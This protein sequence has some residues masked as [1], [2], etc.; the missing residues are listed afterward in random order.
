[1]AASKLLIDS[2]LRTSGSVEDY[3]IDIFTPIRDIRAIQLEA[4][5]IPRSSYEVITGFNDTVNIN[6]G[7]TSVAGVLTGG[8]NYLT[9]SDLATELASAL[10]TAT[11]TSA[12]TGTYSDNTGKITLTS[13][14]STFTIE[15]PTLTPNAAYVIGT[16]A[17][18]GSAGPGSTWTGDYPVNLSWPLYVKVDIDMMESQGFGES[19]FSKWTSS[20]FV[21]PYGTSKFGEYEYFTK[22]QGFQAIQ[23][24]SF[25][26]A[27]KIRVKITPPETT[28][29]DRTLPSGWS[30]NNIDHILVFSILQNF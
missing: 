16:D 9:G 2:R 25:G 1:M 28:S 15:A 12:F 8:R 30:L 21:V 10:N 7:G 24:V 13:S 27:Q 14:G 3:Y 17:T 11:T 29:S 20:S 6:Y 23:S 4:A 19:T 18:N 26:N 5:I 22:D